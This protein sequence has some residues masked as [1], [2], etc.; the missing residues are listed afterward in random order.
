[1]ILIMG[2]FNDEP[3]NKSILKTLKAEPIICDSMI[4]GM[5]ENNSDNLFNLTYSLYNQGL[6]TYKY[7]DDWNMLDQIIVSNELLTGSSI[8]YL[9]NTFEIYK[10]EFMVT[11][12]GKYEGTPFP[13]YGGN[14]YLGGYS[15]HFPVIA[16]F[17][18]ISR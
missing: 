6:G 8:N 17:L 12:S 5:S 1:M 9:C 14:R 2:D 4:S 7:K 16:R 3:T 15:D 10:P 13:T 11:H 18:I